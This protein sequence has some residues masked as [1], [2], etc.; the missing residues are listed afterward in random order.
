M[1]EEQFK[2]TIE[3]VWNSNSKIRSWYDKDYYIGMMWVYFN[4]MKKHSLTS[5]EFILP[6]KERMDMG[7]LKK[8]Y[9]SYY[10]ELRNYLIQNMPRDNEGYYYQV[11]M[12]RDD[13][14]NQED[15]DVRIVKINFET[16]EIVKISKTLR[17]NHANDI[18][19]NTK[20]KKLILCHNK[21]HK[22]RLSVISPETL[23][24]EKTIVLDNEIFSISYNEKYDSYVVGLSG[25]KSFRMLDSEFKCIDGKK[26]SP[27]PLTDRYVTQGICSDD[28]YVYFA[29][30]DGRT[31]NKNPAEFQN[32][33]AVYSWGGEFVG[34][35][36]FNVGVIE[37]ENLS[38]YKGKMY[39]VC[40]QDGTM[41][42]F[43]INL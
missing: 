33:I 17:L 43:E 29:F 14:S 27:T 18:T 39:L 7:T 1:R 11:F 25:G 35:L 12:R 38:F 9:P 34:L 22:D 6:P 28:E 8:Y 3:Q 19:Y 42:C 30:W 24:V 15:N 23:E 26:Y 32:T 16:K 31:A 41:R 10:Q 2:Q 36:D 13:A 37:P 4:R 20:T 5:P 40:G 21:P